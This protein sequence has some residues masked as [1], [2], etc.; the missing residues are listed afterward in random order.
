MSHK[1]EQ[2]AWTH[3]MSR[4]GFLVGAA[5]IGAIGAGAL[6]SRRLVEQS[7]SHEKLVS[8][9]EE[10]L[11]GLR[12]E[13]VY[14]LTDTKAAVDPSY[15]VRESASQTNRRPAVV[16]H[17]GIEKGDKYDDP[18]MRDAGA[19]M[20]RVRIN[21]G[22][23]EVLAVDNDEDSKDGLVFKANQAPEYADCTSPILS[24]PNPRKETDFI[25]LLPEGTADGV[26][27]MELQPTLR[28]V[29]VEDFTRPGGGKG[30]RVTDEYAVTDYQHSLVGDSVGQLQVVVQDGIPVEAQLINDYI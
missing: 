21:W 23:L 27:T 15:P 16:L 25:L 29:F 2:N 22:N 3:E 7:N 11:A 17:L 30:G 14:D 8:T 28:N 5:T 4:R 6:L 24:E 12:L 26:K 19:T 20:D 9:A 10:K 18:I 13:D 1:Q